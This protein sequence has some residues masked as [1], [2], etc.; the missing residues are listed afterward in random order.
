MYFSMSFHNSVLDN[1]HDSVITYFIVN[2]CGKYSRHFLFAVCT[3]LVNIFLTILFL[4]LMFH[5]L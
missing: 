4:N 1:F 3:D 5:C 2:F